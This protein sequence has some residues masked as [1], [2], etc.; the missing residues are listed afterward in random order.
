MPGPPRDLLSTWEDNVLVLRWKHAHNLYGNPSKDVNLFTGIF[1]IHILTKAHY[2]LGK[3]FRFSFKNVLQMISTTKYNTELI[4][5]NSRRRL[6]SILAHHWWNTCTD[7]VMLSGLLSPW[8]LWTM[9]LSW[10]VRQLQLTFLFGVQVTFGIKLTNCFHLW[11]ET[12]V[13]FFFQCSLYLSTIF[14]I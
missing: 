1:Y 13:L 2:Q 4:P 11:Q 7:S 3:V 14:L 9:F 12:T 10:E 8:L 6:W 5:L